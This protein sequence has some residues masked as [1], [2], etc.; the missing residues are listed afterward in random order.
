MVYISVLKRIYI[1]GSIV[2]GIVTGL[3]I[4]LYASSRSVL[5][6]LYFV[7]MGVLSIAAAM[8]L[9]FKI[10]PNADEEMRFMAG[11]MRGLT[12]KKKFKVALVLFELCIVCVVYIICPKKWVCLYVNSHQFMNHSYDMDN[13]VLTA[14]DEYIIA[15]DLMLNWMNYKTGWKFY[16]NK[17][18]NTKVSLLSEI[19]YEEN[20]DWVEET[21]DIYVDENLYVHYDVDY[22][23]YLNVYEFF[24]FVIINF[25]ALC[26]V[27]LL[28]GF[29]DMRK[30]RRIKQV[31]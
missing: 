21:W 22:E 28:S 6:A 16:A 19:E 9:M 10:R 14:G 17:S 31:T 27:F 11:I 30:A 3:I 1:K 15:K 8:Y 25:M 7:C 13:D 2:T 23:Y 20:D 4:F 12:I 18:G 24:F 26:V 29:I 5:V